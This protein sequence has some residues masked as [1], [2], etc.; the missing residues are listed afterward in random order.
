LIVRAIAGFTRALCKP[1]D[2]DEEKF[3]KCMG[4]PILDHV[5]EHGQKSM[6]SAWEPTPEEIKALAA[7]APIYL[8]V[9]GTIHPPVGLWVGKPPTDQGDQ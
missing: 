2:W 7:G 9:L 3:G 4:L 6:M 1:K 8:R 5:D